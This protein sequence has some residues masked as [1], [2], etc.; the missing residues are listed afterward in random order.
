ML[1]TIVFFHFLQSSD[2]RNF[3]IQVDWICWEDDEY[4]YDDD[5]DR[6]EDR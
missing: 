6:D 4:E 3:V 2:E 1:A 5:D